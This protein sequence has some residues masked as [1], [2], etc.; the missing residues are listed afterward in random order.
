MYV[1]CQDTGEIDHEE[2]ARTLK[3]EALEGLA[4]AAN[5]PITSR[6]TM[7]D[8]DVDGPFDHS[9]LLQLLVNEGAGEE[10]VLRALGERVSDEAVVP[11]QSVAVDLPRKQLTR[12]VVLQL[13]LP[14]KLSKE[15]S[16][17]FF[18]FF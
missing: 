1:D 5:A 13:L 7:V 8:V 17:S 14:C 10:A 15:F 16:S 18:F 12:D 11:G 4:V 2:S 3:H 6:P 9:R